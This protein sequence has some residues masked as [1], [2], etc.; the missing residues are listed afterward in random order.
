MVLSH[1]RES[2]PFAEPAGATTVVQTIVKRANRTVPAQ[3][4]SMVKSALARATLLTI[5]TSL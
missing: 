2:G 3:V 1:A 4:Y 5:N